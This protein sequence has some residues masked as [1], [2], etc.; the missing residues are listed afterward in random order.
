MLPRPRAEVMGGWL[1]S[2]Q[3]QCLQSF[4]SAPSRQRQWAM[5]LRSDRWA[6]GCAL[7]GKRG[8]QGGMNRSRGEFHR[9]R[10]HVDSKQETGLETGP[11]LTSLWC[12]CVVSSNC[13]LEVCR[14]SAVGAFGAIP[15]GCSV[16]VARAQ[17]QKGR[18]EMRRMCNGAMAMCGRG[19][20]EKIGFGV[21]PV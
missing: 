12:H 18:L 2:N 4:V 19:G 14:G 10:L 6:R 16:S 11:E 17:Y 1:V 9:T 5:D 3:S 13:R 7:M 8:W 15:V 21:K 20:R